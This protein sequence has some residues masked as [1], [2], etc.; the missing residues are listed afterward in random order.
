MTGNFL[1]TDDTDGHGGRRWKGRAEVLDRIKRMNRI[2]EGSEEDFH[3]E[4]FRAFAGAGDC[5]SS[6]A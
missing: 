4:R 6:R 2:S 5:D 3:E 1:T